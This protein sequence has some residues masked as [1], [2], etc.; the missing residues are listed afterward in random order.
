M[1]FYV[2]VSELVVGRCHTVLAVDHLSSFVSTALLQS[3]REIIFDLADLY[4][5]VPAFIEFLTI[6]VEAAGKSIIYFLQQIFVF[7]IHGEDKVF[8]R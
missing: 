7:L 2:E 6:F 4:V 8:K 1:L 3:L 5:G